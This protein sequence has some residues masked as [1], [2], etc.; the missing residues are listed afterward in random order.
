MNELKPLEIA[1]VF[2][3]CVLSE[4]TGNRKEFAEY[5]GISPCRVT[6][7]KN[8]I[9]HIYKIRIYFSRRRN[10]YYVDDEE[11]HKLTFV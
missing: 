3:R 2:C 7:Y 9:E 10:T 4:N 11:R 1:H 5:L 6:A 8:K